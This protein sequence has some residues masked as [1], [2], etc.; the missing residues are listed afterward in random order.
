MILIDFPSERT[1]FSRLGTQDHRA[2]ALSSNGPYKASLDP[3]ATRGLDDCRIPRNPRGLTRHERSIAIQNDVISEDSICRA[4]RR[5]LA[6]RADSDDSYNLDT[7]IDDL[8]LDSLLIAE[9]IVEL[10]EELNILLDLRMTERMTTLGDLA[11]AL[12]QVRLD[13]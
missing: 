6:D 12:H 4:V 2:A 3:H 13:G 5:A 10:E 8:D 11:R 9:V 7:R 1:R